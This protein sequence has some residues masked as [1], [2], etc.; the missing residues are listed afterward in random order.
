MSR[1]LRLEF[2]GAL[3]H[4]TARGDRRE[5]I[6]E[7]DADRA[8][9]LEV[10]GQGLKRFDATAFSFSYCLMGNLF[11]SSCRPAWPTCPV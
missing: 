4:L 3:Y 11:T 6:F 7:D 9:W 5:P 8:V 10:A 1:P 2:E